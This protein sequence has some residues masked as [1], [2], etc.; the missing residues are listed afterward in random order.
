MPTINI[1]MEEQARRVAALNREADPDITEIF[2]FPDDK[3]LR[4]VEVSATIP[5]STDDQV[6]PFYFRP[7]KWLPIPSG[8]AMIRPDEV[9]KSSLPADWGNWDAAKRI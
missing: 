8:I 2:W 7:G 4:L 3:E 6:H 9:R 1:S 5:I